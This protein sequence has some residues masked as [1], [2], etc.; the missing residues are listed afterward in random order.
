MFDNAEREKRCSS[1]AV[2]VHVEF[3]FSF[4]RSRYDQRGSSRTCMYKLLQDYCSK[5]SADREPEE[6]EMYGHLR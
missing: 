4:S 1:V 5:L 6:N 3:F 2:L